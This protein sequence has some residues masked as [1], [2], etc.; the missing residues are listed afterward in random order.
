MISNLNFKNKLLEQDN[1]CYW[2]GIP[3]QESWKE[4]HP[5]SPTIDIINE[6]RGME[7]DNFVI[8]CSFIHRARDGFDF[9]HFHHVIVDILQVLLDGEH[10]PRYIDSIMMVRKQQQDR[11]IP[12]NNQKET[13]RSVM[14]E[15]AHL[16]PKL[17]KYA[18]AVQ[19]S[20]VSP[21]DSV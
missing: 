7:Y 20:T 19:R 18:N 9:T 13:I 11:I 2:L 4:G 14:G 15:I 21:T 3:F 17:A 12:E 10:R 8:C 6:N 16:N 5:F 1:K